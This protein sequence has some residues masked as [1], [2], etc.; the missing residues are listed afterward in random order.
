MTFNTDGIAERIERI[1]TLAD[2]AAERL[3][4]A[5]D[6]IALTNTALPAYVTLPCGIKFGWDWCAGKWRLTHVN[7][8]GNVAPI[9]DAS[10][11]ARIEAAASID[12]LIVEIERV[13]D[14]WLAKLERKK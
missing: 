9:K 2:Q 13:T 10:R 3:T 8:A 5:E 6:A 11:V 1:N 4:A 7:H 14:E 12:K